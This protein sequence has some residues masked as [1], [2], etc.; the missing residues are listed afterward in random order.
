MTRC[1]K[2]SRVPGTTVIDYDG[3]EECTPMCF[4]DL[5]VRELV[6]EWES[7]GDYDPGDWTTPPW[8]QEVRTITTMTAVFRD[9]STMTPSK[10]DREEL[11]TM[12][13][14]RID[15]QDFDPMDE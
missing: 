12:Y 1:R 11:E 13:Q 5:D 8:G 10:A 4:R 3:G 15:A 9:H 2:W 14:A 7:T 6:I